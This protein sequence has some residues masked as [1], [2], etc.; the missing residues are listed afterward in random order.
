M[1]ASC[2][3]LALL[4]VG[5]SSSPDNPGAG[6]DDVPS[7]GSAGDATVTGVGGSSA[8]NASGG[9]AGGSSGVGGGVGGSSGA[10]GR[11]VHD[12][13]DGGKA[14]GG[15]SD[16]GAIEA[17]AH[18]VVPC[19]S[20]QVGVWE[21]ITP[22]GVL[23]DPNFKAQKGFGTNAFLIDGSNSANITLGTDHMGIYRTTDCGATWTKID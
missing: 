18:V 2:I 16:A 9:V 10:G 17:A 21:N 7:G 22:P 12:T 13:M 20:A 19:A 8:G 1:R 23:A 4:L 15:V 6:T 3:G 11:A 14:G 5:C